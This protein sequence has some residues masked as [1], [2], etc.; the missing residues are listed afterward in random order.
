MEQVKQCTSKTELCKNEHIS[1]L[2]ADT[3]SHKVNQVRMS[4]L[5]KCGDLTLELFCEISLA[6][7][8]TMVRKFELLD[9]DIVLFVSCFKDVRAGTSADLFL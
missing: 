1:V 9:G 5:Y 3:S 8:L 6:S 2:V 7:V 4:D